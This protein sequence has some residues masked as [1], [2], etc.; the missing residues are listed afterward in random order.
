V[1]LFTGI[2]VINSKIVFVIVT[3][4]NVPVETIIRKKDNKLEELV[5]A[6]TETLPTKVRPPFPSSFKLLIVKSQGFKIKMPP[7]GRA[8]EN[9][10]HPQL[11]KKSVRRAANVVAKDHPGKL[12]KNE[13]PKDTELLDTHLVPLSTKPDRHEVHVKGEIGEQS[14]H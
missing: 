3:P 12:G 14:K 9:L 8:S 10:N 11:A 2:K 7:K 6:S 4:S 5:P 13:K 1:H